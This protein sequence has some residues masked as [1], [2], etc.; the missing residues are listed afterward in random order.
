MMQ[1]TEK[2][3]ISFN[4]TLLSDSSNHAVVK[5]SHTSQTKRLPITNWPAIFKNVKV[6]QDKEVL[7]PS[8]GI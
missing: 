5:R 7:F 1:R 2:N 3:T 4:I 8:Q 6:V